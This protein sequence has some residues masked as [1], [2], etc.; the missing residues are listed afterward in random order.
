M[1]TYEIEQAID[2]YDLPLIITYVDYRIVANPS[3]LSAYW[4]NALNAR[5]SNN[6]AKAIHIP[7]IKNALLS[8]INQFSVHEQPQLIGSNN[9]YSEQAHID[10]GA[11]QSVGLMG[12]M[13]SFA[14]T[15]K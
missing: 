1:L 7:F 4:P 14:N 6:S 12:S 8:A 10:F 9:Y 3:L 11:F 13:G 5:L 2:K 15:R